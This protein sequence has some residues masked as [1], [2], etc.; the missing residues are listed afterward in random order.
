MNISL[1]F[2]ENP[3]HLLLFTTIILLLTFA[4]KPLSNMNFQDMQMF[5]Q[6]LE[7]MIWALPFFLI[8]SWLLYLASRNFLYSITYTRIHVI[9]TVITILLILPILYNGIHPSTFSNER[10]ESIGVLIQILT[11]IFVL[12]QLTYLFN[13]GLGIRYKRRLK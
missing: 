2:K 4:L 12:G 8:F 3:F 1:N 9:T 13:L 6:P 5:G 11:W 10:H 7:N